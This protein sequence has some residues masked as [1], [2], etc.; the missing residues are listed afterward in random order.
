MCI[1]EVFA[2]YAFE[3]IRDNPSVVR[4]STVAVLANSEVVPVVV[5]SLF[6]FR[7]FVFN[8]LLGICV[9]GTGLLLM[10]FAESH[11]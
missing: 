5:L 1:G 10:S 4:G 6:I 3:A 9:L 8:A 2:Y 11:L 7:E